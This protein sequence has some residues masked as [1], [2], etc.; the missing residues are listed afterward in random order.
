MA[1]RCITWTACAKAQTG[2]RAWR[3]SPAARQRAAYRAS[4]ALIDDEKKKPVRAAP[5]LRL[6]RDFVPIVLW[7]FR[8]ER[9]GPRSRLRLPSGRGGRP[10]ALPAVE[11]FAAD[12]E[13]LQSVAGA[14][15]R[16]LDRSGDRGAGRLIDWVATDDDIES[17]GQRAKRESG[18]DS[19]VL[20]PMITG[21]PRVVSRKCRMSSGRCQSNRLLLPMTRF[22]AT[23]AISE[24][25]A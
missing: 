6:A 17:P 20:R 23:A 4:A 2:S 7:H 15:H 18:N 13:N 3:K 1:S 8:K 10:W 24:S 22:L 9:V 19:Q 25:I 16:V 12:D 14:K 11:F 21:L 5:C